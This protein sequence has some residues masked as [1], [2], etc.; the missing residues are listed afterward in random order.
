MDQIFQE[1]SSSWVP[2]AFYSKK[3]STPEGKYSAFDHELFAAYSS[4]RHFRFM[5]EGKQFI[6]FTDH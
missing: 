3:L 2:L 6:L 4:L 1:V 5:L